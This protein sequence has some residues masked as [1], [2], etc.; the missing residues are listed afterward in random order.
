MTTTNKTAKA[1]AAI[2]C[3]ISFSNFVATNSFPKVAD[4][5]NSY[6]PPL[7]KLLTS[8]STSLLE[9]VLYVAVFVFII[10]SVILLFKKLSPLTWLNTPFLSI[11]SYRTLKGVSEDIAEYNEPIY[12]IRQFTLQG[13]NN[14]TKPITTVS[15]YIQSETTSARLPVLLDGMKPSETYGIPPKCKFK[16]Q[17]IFP[18]STN[19]YEGYSIEDYWKHFGGFF[20]SLSLD[21]KTVFKKYP[22]DKV[23]NCINM[24]IKELDL[25][26]ENG[27]RVKKRQRLNGEP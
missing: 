27:P 9:V 14:S 5:I 4:N 2:S 10:S 17:A 11:N 23:E 26:S 20:L 3:I 25:P 22:K 16:I 15:G 7:Q 8:Y 21:G 6:F 24:R 12:R 19:D 18:S 13:I 1:L